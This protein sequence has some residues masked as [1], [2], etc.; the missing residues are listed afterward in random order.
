MKS[1]HLFGLF[2]N[3]GL[4]ENARALSY[5]V[6][7]RE[8]SSVGVAVGSDWSKTLT[9]LRE[10]ADSEFEKVTF[11]QRDSHY[12]RT[13]EIDTELGRV[14]CEIS[15]A[16]MALSSRLSLSVT[17]D[18]A[19][20]AITEAASQLEDWEKSQMEIGNDESLLP[21]G[22]RIRFPYEAVT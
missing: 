14:S 8:E 13:R 12:S 21:S 10:R 4:R 19:I 2:R 17:Q 6:R 22:V 11:P 9:Q 1:A 15:E 16:T 5:S 20:M 3:L 18:Q 7:A